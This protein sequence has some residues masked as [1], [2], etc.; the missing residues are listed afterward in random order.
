MP[1]TL[2]QGKWNFGKPGNPGIWKDTLGISGRFHI[3]IPP[4]KGP[5]PGHPTITGTIVDD[6]SFDL[7]VVSQ[8]LV[9]QS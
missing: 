8:V 6:L 7:E 9:D 3:T 2:M 1:N 5:H 4:G